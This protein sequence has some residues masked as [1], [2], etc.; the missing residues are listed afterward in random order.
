MGERHGLGTHH[1]SL[2]QSPAAKR[3]EGRR[4]ACSCPPAPA[5]LGPEGEA[6]C[7]I[8]VS[9]AGRTSLQTEPPPGQDKMEVPKR[10]RAHTHTHRGGRAG[11]THTYWN[12]SH[13]HW[14]LMSHPL[15]S[16][17]RHPFQKQ[18]GRKVQGHRGCH[19]ALLTQGRAAP[20]S[21]KTCAPAPAGMS[22]CC[23]GRVAS[24]T[25]C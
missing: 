15:Q 25:L 18:H 3:E 2:E 19:P 14:C 22:L 21:R 6:G 13:C 4:Q 9:P 8:F 24:L 11:E 23:M 12:C 16:N 20:A 17:Q 5:P 1:P 7:S 10:A